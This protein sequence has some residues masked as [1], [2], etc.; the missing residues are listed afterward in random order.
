MLPIGDFTIFFLAL[1]AQL[2]LVHT[3]DDREF[4]RNIALRNFY[5]GYKELD[6]IPGEVVTKI[7]FE[8][9]GKNSYFNFEKVS[10]RTHLDIA[11]VNSAIH[12]KM[13]GNVIDEADWLRA[14]LL[15]FRC[16]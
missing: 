6:K 13:N 5:K 7:W 4:I 15:R 3:S 1:N 2:R 9:P 16:I 8:L 11:S 10:K 14:V 12:I